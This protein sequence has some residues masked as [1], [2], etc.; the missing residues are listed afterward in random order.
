M[1]KVAF[2][3]I[4]RLPDYWSEGF[5]IVYDSKN[6]KGLFA[7]DCV[8]GFFKNGTMILNFS[9]YSIDFKTLLSNFEF[10]QFFID[11]GVLYCSLEYSF[12]YEDYTDCSIEFVS[13]IKDIKEIVELEDLLEPYF[14]TI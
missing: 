2:N 12:S 8:E 1:K 4:L 10:M 13:V 9:K 5:I 3:A 7:V 11:V 14:P 6:I